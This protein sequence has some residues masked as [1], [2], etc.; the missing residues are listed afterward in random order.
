MESIE[1]LQKVWPYSVEILVF[2]FEHPSIN[3]DEKNCD[4]FEMECQKPGRN[5]H[6]METSRRLNGDDAPDIFKFLK[7]I[8]GAEELNLDTTMYFLFHPDFD[9]LEYHYG[10]SLLDMKDILRELVKKLDPSAEL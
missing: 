7:E 5:I 6:I 1:R 10:K 9:T 2:P 3:Y 4:D 8:M